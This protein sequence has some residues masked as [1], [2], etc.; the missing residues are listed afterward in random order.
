[1]K[2]DII[3]NGFQYCGIYPTR[4]TICEEDFLV[5]RPFSDQNSRPTTRSNCSKEKTVFPSPNNTFSAVTLYSILHRKKP[6]KEKTFF[7][8]MSGLTSAMFKFDSQDDHSS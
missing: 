4:N 7:Q 8:F 1:M 6:G 3:V 5:N 2:R